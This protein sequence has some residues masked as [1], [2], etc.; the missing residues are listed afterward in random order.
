MA[1]WATRFL[2]EL[3]FDAGGLEWTS[4]APVFL[5]LFLVAVAASVVPASRALRIDPVASLR[6]D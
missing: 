1:P 4:L 6:S 2:A 3:S 5:L